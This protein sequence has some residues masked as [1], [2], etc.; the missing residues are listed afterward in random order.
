M[1][2]IAVATLLAVIT[3]KSPTGFSDAGRL[4][5]DCRGSRQFVSGYVIGWLDKWNRDDFLARRGIAGSIPSAR[6]MTNWAYFGGSVGVD[7][8]IPAQIDPAKIIGMFCDFLTHNPTL[9]D[10]PAED[11]MNTFTGLNFPCDKK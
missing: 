3:S 8:C 10:T 4:L 1:S 5:D 7:I 6:A 11:V 2:S 9:K